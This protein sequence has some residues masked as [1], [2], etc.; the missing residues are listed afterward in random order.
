MFP[1]PGAG[2]W[3]EGLYWRQFHH[4]P[5]VPTT[6]PWLGPPRSLPWSSPRKLTGVSG[7]YRGHM[8]GIA[9]VCLPSLKRQRRYVNRA[10]RQMPWNPTAWTDLCFAPCVLRRHF[11][12]HLC[13]LVS[14]AQASDLSPPTQPKEATVFP[15]GLALWKPQ[16]S[17]WVEESGGS[18]TILTCPSGC[19]PPLLVT[20]AKVGF[21]DSKWSSVASEVTG[22]ITKSSVPAA[23]S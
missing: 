14:S 21:T 7:L 13:L 15:G 6:L 19:T 8:E 3:P 9:L 2:A 4:W 18:L 20:T 10:T 17:Q 11:R 23:H 22:D 12:W 1:S 5:S 16:E